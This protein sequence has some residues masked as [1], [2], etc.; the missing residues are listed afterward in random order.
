MTRF[1]LVSVLLAGCAAG[2]AAKPPTPAEPTAPPPVAE[3]N[4]TPAEIADRA[5][6]SVVFIKTPNMIGTGFVVWQ[7]GR[8]ATNLH[9][10]AGS[11]EAQITLNDGRSFEQVEVLGIDQQRDLAVLRI[12]VTGLKP[13]PLGDSL[14]VKPGQH[15]VAIGH[16]LGMG[17]TVSD[18]LVSAVRNIDAKLTLLQISAPISPGSS[19]G[20]IFNEHGEVIGVA[21]LFSME[22]QNLNFGMP[23]MYLKPLLLAERGTPLS[24]FATELDAALLEGCSVDDVKLAIGEIEEAI[25][26]GSAIYNKGDAQGCFDLYQKTSLKIVGALK[27]CTGVRET[28]LGGMTNANRSADAKAKAWAMRH[29]FDRI[30]GAFDAAVKSSAAKGK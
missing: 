22:G 4:Y 16:P 6:P 10:I 14:A 24:V 29:A 2:A 18:G 3:K 23:V 7:D 30:L 19:G 8:I 9:V 5:L 1:L 25:K 12:P 20:P 15:V 13:L 11:K 26:I 28:L 21:T 27:G 17:N